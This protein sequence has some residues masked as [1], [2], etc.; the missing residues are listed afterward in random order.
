ML[1]GVQNATCLNLR[2]RSVVM[3]ASDSCLSS[4]RRFGP[5]LS[6]SWVG[7]GRILRI[8]LLV[9]ATPLALVCVILFGCLPEP[10][11][12]KRAAAGDPELGVLKA[13]F[14]DFLQQPW[15]GQLSSRWARNRGTAAGDQTCGT[16]GVCSAC[17]APRQL[18][19]CI[20]DGASGP[21]VEKMAE[22]FHRQGVPVGPDNWT[23]PCQTNRE[24]FRKAAAWRVAAG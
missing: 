9:L 21:Q 20:N 3:K 8:L 5:F 16:C 6:N 7:S 23:D 18:A 2:K 12:S 14:A 17:H 4:L 19:L 15:L 11:L 10:S 22:S 1:R 13:S 24:H